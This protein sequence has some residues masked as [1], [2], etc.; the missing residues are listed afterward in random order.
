VVGLRARSCNSGDILDEEQIQARRREDVLNS[1]SQIAQKLRTRFGESLA[2]VRKY[3][4]PLEATTSSL[5]ALKEYSTGMKVNLTSGNAAS[6]PFYRRSVEIDPGFAM[7]YAVLGIGYTQLGEWAL[8]RE[9]TIKAW[10]LR[11]RVSDRER[12]FIDFT[13]DRQVTGNLEKAFQT[14]QLWAQTYP[15]HADPDPRDLLGGLAPKGTGRWDVVID[16]ATKGI[17]AQP[18][19]GLYYENLI[20]TY[21]FLDRFDDA[22]R[23]LRQA[24]AHK[25]RSTSYL[26]FQYNLGLVRGDQQEIDEAIAMAKGRRVEEHWLAHC[27]AL[28]LARSGRVRDARRA[29]S[30]AVERAQGEGVRETAAT[31]QAAR[32]VWEALLGQTREAQKDA[33]QALAG[34]SSR[35]VEYAV[36]LADG[37]GADPS[38]AEALAADLDRRFPGDT[39]VQFT[40]L[41]VLRALVALGRHQPAE[42]IERLQ[43]ALPYELAINGLDINLFVGGLHSAYVRGQAMMAAHR[44]ADA[45]TEF[46]KLIDHR[47]IVGADPIGALAYLQLGRALARSG[48]TSKAKDA[49]ATFLSLWKD[50]DS[51][52]PLLKTARAEY[53]KLS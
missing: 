14:L 3:S 12:F 2:T 29:S 41:P 17:V 20:D 33:A 6:I 16:E 51:D 19:R 43:I 18:D 44:Y 42:S 48:G 35:D 28:G 24:A 46:H 32:A 23:V 40:Y 25:L 10:Q 26:A 39:F 4:V 5:E 13:Y 1:L 36:G 21:F 53:R 47:G 34:S 15:K 30:L 49:Y 11:D 50:A 7:P 8:A 9:N 31:Y 52:V 38:G 22:E 45:A 27:Q 37:F